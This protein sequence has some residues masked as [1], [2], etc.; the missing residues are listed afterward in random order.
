MTVEQLSLIRYYTPYPRPHRMSLII[1]L[2]KATRNK[3]EPI[4]AEMDDLVNLLVQMSD[5]EVEQL[6]LSKALADPPPE[7]L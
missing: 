3:P 7:F 1:E 2:S 5:A 6:D 4:Q